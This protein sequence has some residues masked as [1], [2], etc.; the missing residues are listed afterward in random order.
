MDESQP[1][2]EPHD[3]YG[4]AGAPDY[5]RP[6]ASARRKWMIPAAIGVVVL[7][8]GGFF[9]VKALAGGGSSSTSTAGQ[10]TANGPGANPGRRGT[11]GTLQSIDGSTLTVATFARGQN[12]GGAAAGGNTTTVLTSG[13]TKFYKSVSGALSDIKVGDRVTATGTPD[14]TNALTAARITDTGT[15]GAFGRGGPGGGG[16][17]RFNN[18][19]GANAQNGGSTPPSNPNATRPD[20]NSFA[21]GTVKSISGSTITVADNQG[22]TKTV[23]TNASTAVSVL[24]AVAISDLQTGQAVVVTGKT[25]SDGTVSATNVVQ[26]IGGFGRGG[27]FGRFGGGGNGGPGN[28]GTDSPTN[29]GTTTQ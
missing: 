11:V 29:N 23:T 12:G 27:G 25:N 2:V 21:N 19:N 18:P 5:A 9:G 7:A 4:G 24:K 16:A 1:E 13:S 6:E 3:P 14:G 26:G 28:P 20:P 8:V 22:A 17:R 15:M 10:N